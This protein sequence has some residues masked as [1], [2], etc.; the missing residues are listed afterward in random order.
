MKRHII[1]FLSAVCVV[2]LSG[3]LSSRTS[4]MMVE[5]GRLFI[6]D[7]AFAANIE[8]VRDACGKTNDG[9]LHAQV[10]LKNTNRDDFRCQ[11]RFEWRDANGMI[12]THQSSLWCPLL[13]HGREVK[14]LDAVSLQQNAADF[15]LALRRE[16]GN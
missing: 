16:G 7:P 13:L 12:Q 6:E 8:V 15:R 14:D 1:V 4:G 9:F 2:S 3:C 11:Y 5:R 10:T